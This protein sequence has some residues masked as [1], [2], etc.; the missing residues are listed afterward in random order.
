MFAF[1]PFMDN[2]PGHVEP[3]VI[4]P[5]S[6]W[7]ESNADYGCMMVSIAVLPEDF[8]VICIPSGFHSLQQACYSGECEQSSCQST[9]WFSCSISPLLIFFVSVVIFS[10][11]LLWAYFL[12][13]RGLRV[14][15]KFILKELFCP[16]CFTAWPL[17]RLTDFQRLPE[18]FHSIIYIKHQHSLLLL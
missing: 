16:I 4:S 1:K 11:K 5:I 15:K 17:T 7:N 10:W 14:K 13:F 6:S 2:S 9:V 3:D 18:A 12:F 8:R